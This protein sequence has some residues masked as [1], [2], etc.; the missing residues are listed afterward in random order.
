MPQLDRDQLGMRGITACEEPWAR[1][2]PGCLLDGVQD[3]AREM[4][5]GNTSFRGAGR[6]EGIS[7]QDACRL[8]CGPQGIKPSRL[9]T[10]DT[11]EEV[12]VEEVVVKVEVSY[13]GSVGA[14][15]FREEEEEEQQ[16]QEAAGGDSSHPGAPSPL[17]DAPPNPNQ[18]PWSC[19]FPSHRVQPLFL[20]AQQYA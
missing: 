20:S 12:E 19:T 18:F 4:G 8:G 13:R 3:V 16:Q 17:V 15:G 5:R 11:R 1:R 6:A 10:A 14:D 2:D 7:L 9:E